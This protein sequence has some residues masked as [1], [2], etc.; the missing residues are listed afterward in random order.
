[1]KRY[2][3]LTEGELREITVSENNPMLQNDLNKA[4]E[5]AQARA[6]S[7]DTAVILSVERVFKLESRVTEVKPNFSQPPPAYQPEDEL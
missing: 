2:L 7:H 1:M 6:A 5:Y 3:V 4:I